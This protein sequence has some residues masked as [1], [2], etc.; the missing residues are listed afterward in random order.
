MLHILWA[1]MRV[2]VAPARW[3]PFAT[4]PQRIPTILLVFAFQ[5]LYFPI[6]RSGTNTPRVD[7]DIIDSVMPLIGEFSI[8]YFAGAVGITIM[9]FVGALLLPRELYMQYV[10]TLVFAMA[11]GFTIWALF[12]AHVYKAPFEPEDDFDKWTQEYLHDDR[13]YGNHNAIPSSHVYYM[14]IL[15][16]FLTRRWPRQWF[17]FA[18]LA[19]L[20]AWSTLLTHQHYFLDVVAGFALTIFAIWFARKTLMPRVREIYG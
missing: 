13:D 4:G 20:N 15:L 7:L 16:Y 3:D 12:P 1:K 6:N 14:T 9:V 19:V 8:I 18:M 11:I 17:W 10:V 5:L 2:M